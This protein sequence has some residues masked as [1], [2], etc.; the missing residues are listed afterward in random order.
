MKLEFTEHE[1]FLICRSLMSD[2]DHHIKHLRKIAA[3]GRED[4]WPLRE[5]ALSAKYERD[6]VT[7]LLDLAHRNAPSKE[8]RDVVASARV[9]VAQVC[10][11]ILC[12]VGV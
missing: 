10:E 9:K 4:Q 8:W 6:V 11:E 3:K 1:R 7:K 12:E 5:V 2:V